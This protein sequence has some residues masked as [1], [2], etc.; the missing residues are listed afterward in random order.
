M[1]LSRVTFLTDSGKQFANTVAVE[2]D[3]LC[4]LGIANPLHDNLLGRLRGDTAKIDVLHLD[5]PRR[6]RPVA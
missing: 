6:C 4:A 1:T 5:L 3:N 2:V